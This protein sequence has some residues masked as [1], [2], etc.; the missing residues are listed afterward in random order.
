MGE[1]IVDHRSDLEHA[2]DVVDL[3]VGFGRSRIGIVTL[4]AGLPGHLV[5]DRDPHD[6]LAVA[7][8][9]AREGLAGMG[10]E[11]APR[12]LLE[13]IE[14]A[15]LA[16]GKGIR[17]VEADAGVA[18]L[19]GGA[20]IVNECRRQRDR[21]VARAVVVGGFERAR[22]DHLV[23]DVLGV[24][25]ADGLEL[26]RD[27]LVGENGVVDRH[28]GDD[29]RHDEPD[30]R[31]RDQDGDR[32][33]Q[34]ESPDQAAAVREPRGGKRVGGGGNAHGVSAGQFANELPNNRRF[35]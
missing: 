3:P 28:A 11:V 8:F 12:L 35:P 21:A 1:L 20:E 6:L 2:A 17:T 30:Q 18:V 19:E 27:L 34:N 14:L 10:V 5:G 31:D 29:A 33:R 24:V 4:D 26:G 32:D 15:V 16:V 23:D 25:G 7:R 13:S 22:L 9:A